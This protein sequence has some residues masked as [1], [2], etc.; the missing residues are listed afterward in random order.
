MPAWMSLNSITGVLTVD[1]NNNDQIGPYKMTVTMSTPDSGNQTFETVFITVKIC[2]ITGMV[3]PTV[4]VLANRSVLVYATTPL[5]IDIS[6][7]GFVQTPACGYGLIN[8]FSWTIPAGAPIT[9]DT[10]NPKNWYKLTVTTRDPK[11]DASYA[12]SLNVSSYYG[13]LDATYTKTVTF[14]IVVTDPCLTTVLTPFA[15]FQNMTIECG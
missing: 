6:S 1:P 10:A 12:V 11:K 7:P 15:N 13:G 3:D 2:V 8:T 4:P 5:V 14:N 9:Q